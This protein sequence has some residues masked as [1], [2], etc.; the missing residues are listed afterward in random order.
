MTV[1]VTG[2]SY[3]PA[4]SNSY[5]TPSSKEIA[6][7][8][9]DV[10]QSATQL[11][12]TVLQQAP[13]RAG[14]S[15]FEPATRKPLDLGSTMPP[16]MLQQPMDVYGA[17]RTL[18]AHFKFAEGVGMNGAGKGAGDGNIGLSE[19]KR[20]AEPNSGAPASLRDAAKFMLEH[21]TAARSV[22]QGA[23]QNK[24][25]MLGILLGKSN[26][27]EVHISQKDLEAFV[28]SAPPSKEVSGSLG[29]AQL[30]RQMTVYG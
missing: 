30:A 26:P 9:L 6:G 1:N 20:L 3:S 24:P 19:L 25:D 5:N 17:A 23:S 21:S 29:A 18:L 8:A 10:A 7:K 14:S 28:A 2:N 16:R 11:A 4:T 15:S 13:Q 12:Q 22:D 27:A